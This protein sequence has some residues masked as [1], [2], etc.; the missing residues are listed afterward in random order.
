M[1]PAWL[2]EIVAAGLEHRAPAAADGLALLASDDELLL[3]VVAAAARVRRRFFG[4]RVK[5]NFLVSVKSGGCPEDC[6]Y[7][8]QGRSSEAEILR[9]PWLEPEAAAE[10]AE[11][12]A[13]AGARRVCLVASGRGPSRRD[14]ARAERTIAA[15]GERRPEL[16]I[17]LSLGLLQEA[18]AERLH[19][20]GADA[21]NHNLNTSV[22][23]YGEICTTHSYADRLGTLSRAS[24][25]GL[26]LCSGAIF[27]MGESDEDVVELALFLRE[28]G[29]DS[30]PV[31]F[32]IPFEGTPLAGRWRLTPQRCLR[33]LALMRFAF[34]DAE[35][36]LAAGREI[37]LRTAQPLALQ[38]ADSIFLG[39]YLTSE[40]Q[41]A[42]ADLAM[43][44]DAGLVV[45]GA[46]PPA[47]ADR[48][49]SA[50]LRRRGPGTDAAA[51]S[52]RR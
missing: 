13:A 2:E 3:D 41:A 31:N 40:G 49:G 7:C 50:P 6:G 29:P 37:H 14:L 16:E 44:R 20:V 17:C 5:L 52:E 24:R 45:E 47:D 36:R 8:S 46:A 11:R 27:G 12:A 22:G 10:L 42:E 15:I 21:Y 34:P 39:D 25:A 23:R 32:L 4:A 18:E 19:E 48:R 43:I 33:I 51:T 9:Y 1:A 30:V 35:L 26:S 28:L 38:I